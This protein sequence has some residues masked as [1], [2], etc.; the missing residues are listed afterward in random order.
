MANEKKSGCFKIGCFGCLGLGAVVILIF[1]L[2]SLVQLARESRGR[3]MV[4]RNASR[5]LPRIEALERMIARGEIGEAGSLRIDPELLADPAIASRIGRIQLDLAY[6]EFE[7]V[8]G[9]PG[10]EVEVEADFEEGA[11]RFEERLVETEDGGYTYTV[12]MRP[13]GGMVGLMLRGAG[14]NPGNSVTIRLPPDRPLDLVGTLGLGSSVLDLGGLWLRRVDLDG[15]TGEHTITFD[16]P[17][18]SPL[19]LFAVRKSIGEL[20]V[21]SL[22]NASPAVVELEQSVG[23]ITVDLG[24]AW[25]TD[26]ELRIS[27]RIGEVSIRAPDRARL[28][29]DSASIGIGERVI[30]SPS[31]EGLPDD[32]PTLRLLVRGQVGEINVR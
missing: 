15:G 1:V 11:Y 25:V 3:E 28:E 23:E 12:T 30:R 10:S 19:E 26:S 16:R 2:L 9:E 18:R 21:E 4:T 31:G 29:I 20:T 7:I 6:G 8:A 22:G 14:S 24:G 27:N 13:R 5:E 32:A 17:L